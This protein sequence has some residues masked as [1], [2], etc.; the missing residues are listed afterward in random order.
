MRRKES[1]FPRPRDVRV[2]LQFKTKDAVYLQSKRDAWFGKS[3]EKPSAAF[4]LQMFWITRIPKGSHSSLSCFLRAKKL[5]WEKNKIKLFG[6]NCT[7]F[8]AWL[9]QLTSFGARGDVSFDEKEVLFLKIKSW[10]DSEMGGVFFQKTID[11]EQDGPLL[12]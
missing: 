5:I 9:R 8:Y 11:R 2:G 3:T 10:E 7:H 6:S 1:K 12:F 4:R